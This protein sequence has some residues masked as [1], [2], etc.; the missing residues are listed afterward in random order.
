[1]TMLNAHILFK[2]KTCKNPTLQDY[3]MKVLRQLL[4]E[5]V[6]EH[7]APGR[8]VVD[9]PVRLTGRLA[10]KTIHEKEKS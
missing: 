5:N 7:P 10:T 6:V 4:E 2:E 3:V 1:M 9:S 8:H